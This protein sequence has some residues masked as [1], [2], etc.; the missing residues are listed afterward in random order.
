MVHSISLRMAHQIDSLRK[1]FAQTSGLPFASLLSAEDLRRVFPQPGDEPIYTPLVTLSM[2]LSQVFDADHSCCQVVAR[3]LAQRALCGEAPCSAGTGAYCKARL[4]LP[5]AAL[6]ELLRQTGARLHQRA[7][8]PWLWQG[9]R[10]KIIDGTTATLTDTQANQGQYPQ[11]DGQKPG[12]GFP[13]VRMGALLCLATGAVLDVAIAPYRGKG[14]GELSL[15]RQLWQHLEPGEV[16]LGDRIYCSYFEIA[17]LQQRGVDVVLHKHQSR[18]TDF[19]TGQRLGRTDHLVVWKKPARPEWMDEATYTALPK[20]LT[21]RELAIRARRPGQKQQRLVLITTL[22][23]SGQVSQPALAALYRQRWH[24]EL[25]LRSIKEAMQMGQLR[26]KTPAMVRKEIWAHLLAYNLIRGHMAAAAARHARQPR[27]ISFTAALQTLN[28]FAFGLQAVPAEQAGLLYDRLWA[29]IV[30]HRVGDRPDR[31]E[32]RAKKR[33][34]K[35][36]PLLTKPRA[37]ARQKLLRR[38]AA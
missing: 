8:R 31:V 14:T 21:V 20:T 25:D 13:M 15:L 9:R 4:R 22:S 33:R 24:A 27:E 17:L 3:L 36:Y 18:R 16:L 32:P 6:Q 11:P 30:S 23:D 37:I 12:L 28:A 34:K 29:A 10:T 7:P 19:R 2:F 5:E 1:T 38:Q 35:D 26:C